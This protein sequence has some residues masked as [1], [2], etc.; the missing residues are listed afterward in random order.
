M[1]QMELDESSHT[2]TVSGR[3]VISV[4]RILAEAG[5]V[6]RTFFTE[7]AAERGRIVHLLTETATP[8]NSFPPGT[9]PELKGY[10]Q[11][12]RIFLEQ[13]EFQAEEV[14]QRHYSAVFDFAGR[15]D[16]VG[17]LYHEKTILDLKTGQGSPQP[18][19]ALQLAGYSIL[20]GEKPRPRRASVLLRPDGTYR[21]NFYRNVR[22]EEVF[23]AALAVA[24]WKTGL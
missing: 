10:L 1:Q 12:W 4:S 7:K 15:P 6:D 20:L 3:R 14:E 19:W 16:R 8:G 22:D 9:P 18:W 11:A 5:I 2:Y 24:K 21:L 13:T 17:L 23:L